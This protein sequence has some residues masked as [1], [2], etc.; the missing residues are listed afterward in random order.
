[1]Q[2]RVIGIGSPFGDDRIGWQVASI[3]Q[4][5]KDIQRFIPDQLHI[6]CSDR[7]GINLLHLLQGGEIVFLI[8][9]VKMGGVIGAIYRFENKEIETVE[10]S[11]SSH[12]FGVGQTLELG[13]LLT[14]LP[15]TIILFGVEVAHIKEQ[16]E[17]SKDIHESIEK[18]VKMIEQ[19]I[20]DILNPERSLSFDGD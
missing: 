1:M 15:E 14:K 8:D 16:F 20:L 17:I 4:Q 19:E 18:L 11:L 12:G 7:P 6:E 13:R 2:V 3:L 5:Q 10:T 9:A